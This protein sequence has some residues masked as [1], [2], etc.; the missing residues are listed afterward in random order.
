MEKTNPDKQLKL[1]DDHMKDLAKLVGTLSG[2][3]WRKQIRIHQGWWRAFVLGVPQGEYYD[4][5]NK[6]WKKVCN[7]V[8]EETNPDN[9]NFI[10]EAASK[11]AFQTLEEREITSSGM[12]D[13]SRLKY[14]LLSSQPLCFNFFGELMEDRD[15]GLIVLQTWW[16]H[17]TKLNQVFFE[18]APKTNKTDDN[19]AFDI[20]F[21]VEHG[22]KT[23][24]I[25]LE[26]K[27]TDSFS[28]KHQNSKIFY[29]DLKSRNHERYSEIFE[30]SRSSFSKEYYE[31]V[32][33]KT[34]NQLF[35]NQLIAERIVQNPNLEYDFVKT[36]LF[37]F[38]GD[39]DALASGLKLKSML[40]NPNS[41]QVITYSDF[42]VAVQKL[43]IDWMKREWTMKLWVR[44][45]AMELSKEIYKKIIDD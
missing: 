3:S 25:G 4:K 26:C 24:I 43:D 30:K 9:I 35:R 42:I 40:P 44:Y 23:G 17:L 16:P 6:T 8:F 12:V 33:D 34:I 28:Y 31:Y 18:F 39:E 32:R 14:N 37:C 13:E 7:R 2:S 21:E 29:G 11:A 38:E 19:S 15:F 41:F 1:K 36:G 20:A 10:G 5:K 27:Y 45:C 22:D